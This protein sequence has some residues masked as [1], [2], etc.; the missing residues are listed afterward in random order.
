MGWMSRAGSVAALIGMLL[1][2]SSPGP[3]AAAPPTA[4]LIDV[5]VGS[6][7]VVGSTGDEGDTVT[8]IQ[9]R[10]GKRLARRQA[11]TDAIGFFQVRLAPIRA[12]DQLVLRFQ[13]TRTVTVPRLQLAGNPTTDR[14]SGRLPTPNGVATIAVSNAIGTF[15]LGGSTANAPTD[16]TGRFA[17]K[18]AGLSGA[19][20]LELTWQNAVDD[21]FRAEVTMAAAEIQDGKTWV[22]AF[23]RS[24]RTV[25]VELRAPNGRLRAT[26][27]VRIRPGLSSGS[28]AFR[29]NGA[30]VAVR[31]GDRI[32]IGRVAGLT[33]LQGALTLGP[34]GAN[35]TCFANQDWIIGTVFGAGAFSALDQGTADGAGT[36]S[37]SWATPLPSGAKVRLMC[38]NANGWVQD[39]TG[40]VL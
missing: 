6:P 1:A 5:T 39:M 20:R 37:A 19:E 2:T 32:R 13:G 27:A 26:A 29:R 36:V 11:T 3:A 8:I 10:G 24:G 21:Q 7:E 35:A 30:K 25:T 40:S 22:R 31:P 4:H 15:S 23:G 16:A 12:G 38:E 14:V 9:K 34:T 18:I 33:V 28:A 17:T